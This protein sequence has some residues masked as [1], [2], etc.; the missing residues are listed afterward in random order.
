MLTW[1]LIWYFF[2]KL[3]AT[4]VFNMPFVPF[5]SHV[6][7]FC[8]WI[9]DRDQNRIDFLISGI[10]LGAKS[11]YGPN[12]EMTQNVGTKVYLRQREMLT[13][14]LWHWLTIHS[15]KVLTQLLWKMKKAVKIFIA[16]FFFF[17]HKN[18]L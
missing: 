8:R 18:F 4:S 12:W 17:F 9:D 6:G 2:I 15:R 3:L 14:V 11:I 10:D 5:V 1:M 7:F 16:F 13:N